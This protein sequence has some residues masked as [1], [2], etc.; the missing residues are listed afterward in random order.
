MVIASIPKLAGARVKRRED[1]RLI[2]GSATYVDDIRLPGMHHL[3]ILRSPYAHARI[4]AIDGSRA[5]AM[6]GVVAVVTGTDLK[7]RAASLLKRPERWPLATD[8]V[9]YVGEPVAAVLAR[10][11][12]TARDAVDLIEVDY[13]ELAAAVDGEQAMLADA[14]R[15]H[16]ALESNIAHYAP[17]NMG[18]AEAALRE[19]DVRIRQRM[20]NQRLAPAPMETRGTV[21][22]SNRGDGTLT[23]WT[24]TQVPHALR[25]TLSR[26]LS[27][28]EERVRVI[29][30]EVGGGFGC[31]GD[32]YPE[33][34]L[35]AALS[36]MT[37]RPVK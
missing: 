2:T 34:V 29:A 27:L 17:L 9:R 10:E 5:R 3:A 6:P 23:V 28:S 14:P 26:L 19:A 22:R 20:L 36:I 4:R 12:A 25:T 13:E 32:V 24:S 35:V 1:P 16:E 7:G 37:G 21:A 8:R 30:P 33:D 31:K 11:Q 18:D 15:V